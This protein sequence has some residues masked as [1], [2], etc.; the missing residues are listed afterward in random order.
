MIVPPFQVRVAS[1][2]LE[3]RPAGDPLDQVRDVSVIEPL[4]FA[5][6]PDEGD[7]SDG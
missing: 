1:W 3:A 2:G 7:G 4:G 6:A 5:I